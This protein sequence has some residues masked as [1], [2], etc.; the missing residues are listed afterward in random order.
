MKYRATLPGF[1]DRRIRVGDIIEVEGEPPIQGLVPVSDD[2]DPVP[3]A[4]VEVMADAPPVIRPRKSKRPGPAPTV[5]DE[6]DVI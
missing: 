5:L 6:P 2:P 3:A 1:I 4:P